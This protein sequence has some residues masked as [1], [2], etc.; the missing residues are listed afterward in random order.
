MNRNLVTSHISPTQAV[1]DTPSP[2]RTR[3]TSSSRSSTP[4]VFDDGWVVLPRPVD[5]QNPVEELPPHHDLD[6]PVI[7]TITQAVETTAIRPLLPPVP[8]AVREGKEAK[9]ERKS[10]RVVAEEHRKRISEVAYGHSVAAHVS[11]KRST[12][13]WGHKPE[14]DE[15]PARTNASNSGHSPAAFKWVCGE[16]IGTGSHGKLYLG[17]NATTGEMMIAK[18][19][20]LSRGQ[21]NCRDTE[22]A[23][24][25][26]KESELSK[27][28]DHPNIVQY[29]GFEETPTTLSIFFEYMPG[30]SISSMLSKHGKL[31]EENT[32]FFTSQILS[33]LEYLHS[34]GI[35]H[36]DLQARN[37][38][39]DPKSGVCKIS[40]F[41]VSKRAAELDVEAGIVGTIYWMPPE[42]LT[43]ERRYSLKVDIWS[44]GCIVLEM[45][46]GSRPWDGHELSIIMMKVRSAHQ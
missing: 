36:C 13:L 25:L 45:L 17:L 26:K 30:G 9:K 24:G 19:V 42:V 43:S 3:A 40:G 16:M 31:S 14:G 37:V 20:E 23:L 35:C 32:Q 28:L 21:P 29:L 7:D 22:I 33:G 27:D 1:Y 44:V 34:N 5:V 11:R 8:S 2:Q 10:I 39:F 4:E 38:L 41:A 18:R 46:T 6:Q 15:T 12:K